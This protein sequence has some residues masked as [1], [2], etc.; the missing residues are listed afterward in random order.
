MTKLWGWLCHSMVAK[1]NTPETDFARWY[2]FRNFAD[3]PPYSRW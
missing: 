1:W 2:K 3:A